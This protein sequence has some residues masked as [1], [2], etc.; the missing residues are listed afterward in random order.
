MVGNGG[1]TSR[2]ENNEIS[3]KSLNRKGPGN[4]Q[5]PFVYIVVKLVRKKKAVRIPPSEILTI[6]YEKP[7]VKLLQYPLRENPFLVNA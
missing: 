7:T 2:K 4:R 1:Q 5:G 3:I 6:S